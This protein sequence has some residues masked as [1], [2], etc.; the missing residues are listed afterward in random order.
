[1]SPF[2]TSV[3][4]FYLDYSDAREDR[5]LLYGEVGRDTASFSYQIKATNAGIY[6]TAPIFAEAMYDREIQALGLGSG[7]I[8]VKAAE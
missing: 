5:V 3:D 1:M 2:A 8:V 7:K 6:E 4:N